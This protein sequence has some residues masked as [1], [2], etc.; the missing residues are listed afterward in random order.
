MM[1]P[2]FERMFAGLE[3]A[4]TKA[5]DYGKSGKATLTIGLMCT[6]GPSKLIDL[7]A[8]FRTHNDGV[9]LYLKDASATALEELLAKGELDIADLA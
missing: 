7:F 2:Y 3:G 6:I 4:K 9:E 1:R 8:A 5:K